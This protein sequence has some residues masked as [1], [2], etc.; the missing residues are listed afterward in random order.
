MHQ[1]RSWIEKVESRYESRVRQP[2]ALQ[3]NKIG[4][5]LLSL[6]ILTLN[7]K[8]RQGGDWQRKG[9]ADQGQGR[10]PLRNHRLRYLFFG[11]GNGFLS[12]RR[13]RLRNYPRNQCQRSS[14]SLAGDLQFVGAGTTPINA[15]LRGAKL[16]TV[17]VAVDKPE[18]DLYESENSHV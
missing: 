10:H 6:L 9:S 12:R 5:L 18:F 14:G 4:V 7:G 17:F 15:A 2:R 13:P 11:Q 3:I 1:F 8:A 16:K